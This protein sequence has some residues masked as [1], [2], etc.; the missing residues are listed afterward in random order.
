MA[1]RIEGVL[2]VGTLVWDAAWVIAGAWDVDGRSWIE[3]SIR[4]TFPAAI[5]IRWE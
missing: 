1:F 5:A 3:C 2:I 4:Q